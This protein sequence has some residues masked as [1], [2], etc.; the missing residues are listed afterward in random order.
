M[1]RLIEQARQATSAETPRRSRRARRALTPLEER[2]LRD[3]YQSRID[4]LR[5]EIESEIRRRLVA[6]RGAEALARSIRK[7]LP[8]DIDVM[9]ATRDELAALRKSLASRCRAS[10]PCASPASAATAAR[11]RSTSAP[12]CATRSR[13]A[14]CR[15]TP[16]SATRGRPSPRSS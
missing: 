15:S 13:P 16:S 4:Q 14:A 10:W 11:V 8:E 2:L 5:K 1:E 12:R 7:P 6:D 9:H 3:E